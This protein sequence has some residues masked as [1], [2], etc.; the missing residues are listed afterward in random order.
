MSNDCCH[1]YAPCDGT[2]NGCPARTSK[3]E[4]RGQALEAERKW[5]EMPIQFAGEEP[6]ESPHVAVLKNVLFGAALA[7]VG[8][9]A[10]VCVGLALY[11]K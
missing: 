5:G 9:V 6:D 8:V 10:G 11:F 2:R 4:T 3:A 1:D 7:L